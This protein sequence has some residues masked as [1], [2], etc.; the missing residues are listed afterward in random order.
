MTLSASE[1]ALLPVNAILRGKNRRDNISYGPDGAMIYDEYPSAS[2]NAPLVIFWFGG[3]WK[4]GRKEMYRFVGHA[5][6]RMGA[7]AFVLDYPKY[8]A[9]TYPGFLDDAVT[10]VRHIQGRYPGRRII[11]MGHSAGGHTALLLGLRRLVEADSVVAMAAPCTINERYW[12]PVFGDAIQ[13]GLT[14]PRNYVEASPENLSVLLFHGAKD[15]TVEV[16]DSISLHGKLKRR[17]KDSQLVVLRQL[18][19]VL[20]VPLLMLGF[21]P[22]ARRRLKRHIAQ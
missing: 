18:N 2:P 9:R 8:P 20:I 16:G 22:A 5:L 14:D 19:H 13:R 15:V 21:L 3:G 10:A 12:R 11:L 4:K 6:Q 7:H 17:G 1:L